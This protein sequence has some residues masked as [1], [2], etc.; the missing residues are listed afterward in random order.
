MP[1]GCITNV[2]SAAT[3]NRT[4]AKAMATLHSTTKLLQ[5]GQPFYQQFI[6]VAD[7]TIIMSWLY[8]SSPILFEG[9]L[10]FSYNSRFPYLDVGCSLYCLA[11]LLI[12]CTGLS[13][14]VFMNSYHQN[15]LTRFVLHDH[16]F[17]SRFLSPVLF[18]WRQMDK[19]DIIWES[20]RFIWSGTTWWEPLTSQRRNWIFS[21]WLYCLC[22]LIS[23]L[24]WREIE[25][26]A[27]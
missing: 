27:G 23:K 14:Y 11:Y 7:H 1:V 21:S 6:E 17:S 19:L 16:K 12:A 8:I 13:F 10:L 22:Y 15:S 4:R 18:F 24:F 3:E 9:C 25:G 5:L 26:R 20:G 2:K